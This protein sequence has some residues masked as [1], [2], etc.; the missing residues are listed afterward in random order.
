MVISTHLKL[1]FVLVFGILM[2]MM[3]DV[4][5]SLVESTIV[6]L[7]ELLEFTLDEIIEHFF[8]TSRHTTQIIVFY[9]MMGLFIFIAYRVLI[10]SKRLYFDLKREFPDWWIQQKERILVHWLSLS[11]GKKLKMISGCTLGVA[12]VAVLVL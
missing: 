7:F 11:I 12:C 1:A 10:Y 4:A 2:V 5:Y 6:G 3:P 9:I 8:H